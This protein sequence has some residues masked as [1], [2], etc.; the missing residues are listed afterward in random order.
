M[1]FASLLSHF[2][3]LCNAFPH[4]CQVSY[5]YYLELL[6]YVCLNHIKSRFFWL[7]LFL[8]FNVLC[9]P[10]IHFGKHDPLQIRIVC[11]QHYDDVVC[12]IFYKAR[13]KVMNIG[14]C[15]TLWTNSLN[16]PTS[17]AFAFV[18]FSVEKIMICFEDYFKSLLLLFS[19]WSYFRIQ[20][21]GYLCFML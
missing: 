18:M 20:R 7:L 13:N 3:F 2:A 12:S 17:S 10:Y 4:S 1:L 6:K 5:V 9:F 19:Q 21:T 11:K 15:G 16:N 14:G 8:I